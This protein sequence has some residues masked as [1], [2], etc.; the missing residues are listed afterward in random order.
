MR[1]FINV[2]TAYLAGE[3]VVFIIMLDRSKAVDNIA[4]IGGSTCFAEAGSGA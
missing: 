4:V 3:P 2:L 1:V